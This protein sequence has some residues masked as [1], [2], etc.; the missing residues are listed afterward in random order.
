MS[1]R[2]RPFG[3]QD[4]NSCGRNWARCRAQELSVLSREDGLH[5]A[6]VIA[7]EGPQVD[8]SS[9]AELASDF[10]K[11]LIAYDEPRMILMI[12]C[13][14]P[15]P[16]QLLAMTRTRDELPGSVDRGMRAGPGEME[17]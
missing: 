13:N 17:P 9:V 16:D 12:A 5:V 11:T 7:T 14:A 15:L 1:L 3:P 4:D 10:R 8:V 2:P 6:Q